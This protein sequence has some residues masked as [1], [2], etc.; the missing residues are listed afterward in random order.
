MLRQ[1]LTGTHLV[2]LIGSTFVRLAVVAIGLV[3][4]TA[5]MVAGSTFESGKNVHISNLHRIEDDLY[6]SG[7]YVVVEGTIVGDLVS[8]GYSTDLRGVIS[9]SANTGGYVLNHT[10]R[11]DGSLRFFSY[12]AI[13]NG[14]VGG[15]VLGFAYII[16]L[17][18]SSVV[19]RD[20]TVF[21]NDVS[22]DGVIKGDVEVGGNSV[23]ISGLIEGNVRAQ[24]EKLTIV[25]PAVI[26]GN[27]TYKAR[28]ADALDT[29]SGVTIVGDV[30]WEPPDE[31][32]EQEESWVTGFILE[33]SGILAAFIFGIIAIRLFK[34]YAQESLVQLRERTTVSVAAGLLGILVLFFCML[35]LFVSLITTLVGLVLLET[36]PAAGAIVMVFST[37]MI[38]I[39]SF[40]SVS[41]LVIL[42]SAKIL[43]AMIIGYPLLK[44]VRRR[45]GPLSK[46]ALLLGL[47]IVSI[48]YAI[49]YLGWLIWIAVLLGGSGAIVLGIK[50][51]RREALSHAVARE[52]GT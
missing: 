38:P 40:L 32:T 2:T 3:G 15:S 48:L 44:L 36:Q 52:P 16:N 29:L 12:N 14:A 50:N 13:L 7:E 1:G 28:E 17:G 35:L 43:V 25:P 31:S 8:T 10:G 39:S 26:R 37:L 49:P 24:A 23:R 47:V 19:E 18:Q 51:C 11:V 45:T 41:G 6:A 42:Y 34:P 9:G 20:V 4:L 5:G 21:A 27:L 33:V 22:L 30:T 46:L